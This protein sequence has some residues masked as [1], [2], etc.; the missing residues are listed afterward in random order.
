M[1]ELFR[2]QLRALLR[3][4]A[5]GNVRVMFPMIASVGEF[6]A[7]DDPHERRLPSPIEAENPHV[8]TGTKGYVHIIE[9]NLFPSGEGIGLGNVMQRNHCSALLRA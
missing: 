8:L 3:A 4:S 1:P 2:T 5:F 6:R 7:A 9:H